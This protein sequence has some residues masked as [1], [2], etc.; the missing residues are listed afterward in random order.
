MNNYYRKKLL[1]YLKFIFLKDEVCSWLTDHLSFTYSAN[2]TNR[3]FEANCCAY[4]FMYS[5]FVDYVILEYKHRHSIITE[6]AKL[7]YLLKSFKSFW[8]HKMVELVKQF[9]SAWLFCY[10]QWLLLGVPVFRLIYYIL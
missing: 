6:I 5:Y 9:I 4:S 8:T 3:V 10:L 1:K 2:I 7:K